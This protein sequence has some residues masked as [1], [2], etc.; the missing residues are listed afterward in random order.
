MEIPVPDIPIR[1]PIDICLALLLR[2]DSSE[3]DGE[4]TSV[5]GSREPV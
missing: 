1:S 4:L 2:L 5:A 3:R